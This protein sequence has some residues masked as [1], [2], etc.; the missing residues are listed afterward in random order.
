MNLKRILLDNIVNG[1]IDDLMC[2]LAF[3]NKILYSYTEMDNAYENY[4]IEKPENGK[5]VYVWDI[6]NVNKRKE[7][8]YRQLYYLIYKLYYKIKTG[9]DFD[10]KVPSAEKELADKLVDELWKYDLNALYTRYHDNLEYMWDRVILVS[11]IREL[12]LDTDDLHIIDKMVQQTK[13][14]D[15]WQEVVGKAAYIERK[16]EGCYNV[17][18]N[19]LMSKVISDS[20]E[21][22]FKILTDKLPESRLDYYARYSNISENKEFFLKFYKQSP[23]KNTQLLA[24]YLESNDM[25]TIYFLEKYNLISTFADIL[26]EII[27]VLKMIEVEKPTINNKLGFHFGSY[28]NPKQAFEYRAILESYLGESNANTIYILPRSS[29]QPY[30]IIGNMKY[31]QFTPLHFARFHKNQE[32]FNFFLKYCDGNWY[33]KTKFITGFIPMI[34]EDL[35]FTVSGSDAALNFETGP[36]SSLID[37]KNGEYTF[38]ENREPQNLSAHP[39]GAKVDIKYETQAIVKR[40]S[41]YIRVVYISRVP[42]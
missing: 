31:L 5:I 20:D 9:S 6:P 1:E 2:D 3:K 39:K 37:H 33:Q 10:Y 30:R 38:Y 23:I 8:R 26:N 13:G 15:L 36:L 22:I 25:E 4:R 16:Y 7:Y 41:P 29:Y 28:I 40:V 27:G 14:T 12:M 32:M 17:F 24:R 18:R 34:D 35:E 42:N 19:H 21:V 11:S